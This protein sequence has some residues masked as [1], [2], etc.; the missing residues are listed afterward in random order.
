MEEQKDLSLP[1]ANLSQTPVVMTLHGALGVNEKRLFENLQN[2]F[3]VTISKAQSKYASNLNYTGNVYHG[4]EMNHYPFSEKDDGYLV[5]VGRISQE[6][7]LHLAIEVAQYLDMPL[8]I[9]AKLNTISD[10][11][12]DWQYFRE[13][14]KP[15]LSG[16][17]RW[18]GEVNEKQEKEYSFPRPQRLL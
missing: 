12:H 17:I 8:I 2:P 16:Q 18:V 14:I 10:A 13:Y 3:L 11:P 1:T 5:F 15:K 7:G 6:K 9:A 4:L